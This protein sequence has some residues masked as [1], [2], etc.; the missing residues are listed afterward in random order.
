[1]P[2]AV[3]VLH[4]M[5]AFFTKLIF[6]AV[7]ML[8]GHSIFVRRQWLRRLGAWWKQDIGPMEMVYDGNFG[9]C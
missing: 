4:L 7:A 5:F 8:M 3:V 2:G 1:M 6:L 9:F